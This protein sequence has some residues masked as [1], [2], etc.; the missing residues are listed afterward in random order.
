VALIVKSTVPCK[1][2]KLEGIGKVQFIAEGIPVWD[3]DATPDTGI[4]YRAGLLVAAPDPSRVRLEPRQCSGFRQIN[5][6]VPDSYAVWAESL[7]DSLGDMGLAELNRACPPGRSDAAA[8]FI[9]TEAERASFGRDGTAFATKVVRQVGSERLIQITLTRAEVERSAQMLSREGQARNDRRRNEIAASERSREAGAAEASR[10]RR[11]RR[12]QLAA[13]HG[14]FD[15]TTLEVVG[16]NPFVWIGKRVGTCLAIERMTG[17]STAFLISQGGLFE[18]RGF[19]A[20][21]FPKLPTT[22]FLVARVVGVNSG[23]VQLAYL[24]AVDQSQSPACSD[25]IDRK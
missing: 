20:A 19:P 15:L 25:Y 21:R 16:P 4:A 1:S 10:Q 11:G 24:E 22:V 12:E 8:A 23:V 9:T 2:G 14:S 3:H 18:V 5:V 13:R 6:I 7:V 17:P